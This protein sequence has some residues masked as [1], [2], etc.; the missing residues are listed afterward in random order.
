[1]AAEPAPSKPLPELAFDLESLL[2]HAAEVF[3]LYT[4]RNDRSIPP[5]DLAEAVCRD[6]LTLAQK[7]GP[8]SISQALRQLST[9][10]RHV[11]RWCVDDVQSDILPVIKGG[12]AV[13]LELRSS[14]SLRE[15]WNAV[16]KGAIRSLPARSSSEGEGQAGAEVSVIAARVDDVVRD[17]R[18]FMQGPP[19]PHGYSQRILERLLESLIE[20]A[21][22]FP[23]GAA[24]GSHLFDIAA[25]IYHFFTRGCSIVHVEPEKHY[26]GGVLVL[27]GVP[28]RG[29]QLTEPRAYW[30]GDMKPLVEASYNRLITCKGLEDL[31]RRALR[32]FLSDVAERPTRLVYEADHS[33]SVP[34]RNDVLLDAAHVRHFMPNE[35]HFV[36]MKALAKYPHAVKIVDLAGES[37]VQDVGSDKTLGRKISELIKAGLVTRPRSNPSKGPVSLTQAGRALL[38]ARSRSDQVR[39]DDSPMSSTGGRIRVSSPA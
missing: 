12:A 9:F 22:L 23:K 29:E 5:P 4:W 24:V 32:T 35:A 6:S 1:M 25:D 26:H 17:L 34:S 20:S 30:V 27:D 15:F 11:W 37:A 8:S 28:V 36:I 7:F 31:K 38:A 10:A 21:A 18:R 13:L 14:Q 33:D 39:V 19:S 16:D 2:D 3:D